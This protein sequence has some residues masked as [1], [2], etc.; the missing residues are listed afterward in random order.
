MED[1]NMSYKFN[2]LVGKKFGRLSV[3]NEVGRSKDRHVLWL[4]ACECGNS[5]IA[6]SRDLLS[7]HTQSCGCLKNDVHTKHGGRG[8][9]KTERLY[10]VW[11][12]IKNRCECKSATG[13]SYYG[14]RGIKL[15]KEWHDYS[16]FRKW[17]MSSGYNSNAP[18]WDCTI[19]RINNDGN[20]E[21]KNC[22]WVSMEIQDQNKR[23]TQH[24]VSA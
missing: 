13:Y 18:Q 20:Y 1:I 15:C 10:F 8:S 19:D 22:R 24:K 16:E 21:P 4:C 12:G 11:R 14:G 7:D 2:N 17:A 6:N 9:Y 3:Q 5:V 23:N